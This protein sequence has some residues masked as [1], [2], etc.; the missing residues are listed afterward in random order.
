MENKSILKALHTAQR[1]EISEYHTYSWLAGRIKDKR[2]SE[3]IERIG[4]DELA[5]YE[6]IKGI[7]H[8]DVRPKKF[9]VLFYRFIS[10][11]FGLSFGLRLME[12]GEKAAERNYQNLKNEIPELAKVFLDEEKHEK[13]L[14]DLIE[15]ERIEYAGSM[16]L[17]LND[18]LMELT[19]VLAGLTFAFQ[20]GK[21]IGITGF[22][23]GVAAAM[24]MAASEYI[25]VREE[26]DKNSNKSS[27]RSALYTGVAYI[28]TVLILIT[29]YF[30]FRNIYISLGVMLTFSIL[31][32][33]SYNFYI[34]TAKGLSLWR[35]FAEMALISISVA[36]ISFL[37]GVIVR[38]VFKVEV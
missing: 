27:L 35:R 17:G 25:S 16:V 34:T 14:L 1:N 22:I 30:L 2:N 6:I 36:G 38:T 24:S 12:E 13:E 21:I 5:H 11:L 8:T 26:A 31:I 4:R 3:I 29:P 9:M 18:A 15:E 20:N 28:I 19:G 7:T 33:L 37:V 32:I 10:L 23:T